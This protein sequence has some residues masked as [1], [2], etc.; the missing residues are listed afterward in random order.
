MCSQPIARA[1]CARPF[2]HYPAHPAMLGAANGAGYAR[3]RAS[4]HCV[5]AIV[6]FST[7]FAATVRVRAR[8]FCGR[9]PPNGAPCGAARGGGKVRRRARTMRARSLRA[10]GCAL[11]EPRSPLANSEGRMPGERATG[12]CFLLVT[13]LCTSKEKLPARPKGEW[14]L[15]TSGNREMERRA[16]FGLTSS[17]V[18]S[19][20]NDERRG[21]RSDTPR[22]GVAVSGCGGASTR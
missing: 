6:R 12:V 8:C 5:V 15:C 7:R 18:E 19:R 20:R 10:H 17:A 13:F 4:L 21:Q 22:Y 9:M 16:G 2:G 3:I 14:K 1:S 11:N